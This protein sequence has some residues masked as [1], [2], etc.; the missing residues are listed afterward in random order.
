M[1]R[2]YAVMC[3]SRSPP[4]EPIDYW[5]ALDKFER[6]NEAIHALDGATTEEMIL[7]KK[8]RC[9]W[10]SYWHKHH[11]SQRHRNEWGDLGLTLLVELCALYDLLEDEEAA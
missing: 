4:S 7:I 2:A 8:N 6:D 5:I 10:A 1:N 11:P 9:G 3:L